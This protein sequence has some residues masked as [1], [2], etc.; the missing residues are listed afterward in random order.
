MFLVTGIRNMVVDMFPSRLGELGY[1]GL[2]NKGYGVKLEHCTS[3]LAISIAYDLIALF[4]VVL[5]VV[6]KQAIGSEVAPW[7]LAAVASLYYSV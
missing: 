2:L 6:L 4:I 1:I 3:S 5:L 7:A